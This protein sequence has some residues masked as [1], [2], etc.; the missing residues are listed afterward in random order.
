MAKSNCD[1]W[2]CRTFL[3][4]RCP[5]GKGNEQITKVSGFVALLI[6]L[7]LLSPGRCGAQGQPA[8]LNFGAEL[9]TKRLANHFDAERSRCIIPAV[10]ELVRLPNWRRTPTS[11]FFGWR[12]RTIADAKMSKLTS[13][14]PQ[15]NVRSLTTNLV[16]SHRSRRSRWMTIR[17]ARA[18]AAHR[19]VADE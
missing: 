5:H 2:R 14:P 10:G 19:F 11:R 3:V 7:G 8:L 4:C 13:P 17:D 6:L 12:N 1:S 16:P 9:D 15:T 18:A